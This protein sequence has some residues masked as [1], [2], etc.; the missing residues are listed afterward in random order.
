MIVWEG[1]RGGV[2]T[3]VG[4]IYFASLCVQSLQDQ[5]YVC[6]LKVCVCVCLRVF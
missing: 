3:V 4:L 6:G 1:R 2:N 5:Q